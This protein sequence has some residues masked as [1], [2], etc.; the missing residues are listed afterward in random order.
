MA[1]HAAREQV[2]PRGGRRRLAPRGSASGTDSYDV[3]RAL[4]GTGV[5]GA[6][7]SRLA[8]T[9]VP[10][11]THRERADPRPLRRLHAVAPAEAARTPVVEVFLHLLRDVA[12]DLTAAWTPSG[13]AAVTSA[14][15]P[16][17][18][19]GAVTSLPYQTW[20]YGP[21]L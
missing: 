17:V 2:R 15:Q 7:V 8:L 19:A 18:A 21:L 4:V 11:A 1:G 3:A 10:G 20:A 13:W 5:G 14:A 6:L 12:A 9:S 16:A